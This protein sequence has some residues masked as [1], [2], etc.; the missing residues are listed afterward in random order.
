[1]RAVTWTP[2]ITGTVGSHAYGLATPTSDM[3]TLGVAA[4]PTEAFH[5]L[6]APTGKA[7]TQVS[8]DPDVAVHEAGK[9]VSLCLSANPTVTEL[10]WLPEDCYQE[11]HPLGRELIALRGSLLGAERVRNAYLGYATQQFR[12]LRDRGTSFSSNTAKRTEKH[13]R[14][15]LRLVRAGMSLYL[16]GE[17]PVRVDDPQ[18]YH[19]FG[20]T[21]AEDAERGLALA[22]A[23]LA[24]AGMAMDSKPSALPDEPDKRAAEAWLL[25]VR[26]HFF[27]TAGVAA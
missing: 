3:D 9:F 22:E 8:T 18:E 1:M 23:T 6:H 5:G 19:D 4:A 27:Q 14:H 10:L 12:R 25:R 13:A 20:R 11:V 7:A 24:A 2:L 15:L 26:A 21:V 16:A 17:L